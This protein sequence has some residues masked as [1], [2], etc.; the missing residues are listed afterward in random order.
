VGYI[1][2]AHY[3]AKRK[4]QYSDA[5]SW[6]LTHDLSEAFQ[7]YLLK[8]SNNLAKE[9]GACEGFSRTKYSDGILPIDTYKKDFDSIV[10]NALNY[11]WEALRQSILDHGLRH[12]TLSAQMPSESCLKWDHKVKTTS[13]ELDFHEICEANNINWEDVENTDA[14]GWYDLENPITV[15][16]LDGDKEVSKLY[17]NGNKPLVSIHLEDG[18]VFKC[19]ATHKFLVKLEDGTTEWKLAAYLEEDDDI[20]EF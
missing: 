16:T 12:S 11:D 3:L 8:A 7:Y 14:V 18:N 4:A 5:E 15:P 10:P 17:Y 1:G 19:T 6:K 20:V 13:G 2:L 9:R